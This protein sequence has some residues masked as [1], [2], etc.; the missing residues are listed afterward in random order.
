V[1]EYCFDADFCDLFEVRGEQRARHGE[2][3]DARIS[4][5]EVVLGY[6]GLDGVLR[7]TRILFDQPVSEL[8]ARRARASSWRWT[9]AKP[10]CS[11]R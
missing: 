1:L 2:Q 4:E 11:R 7:Q 9:P 10:G 8:E 6:K 5:Q 3:Q